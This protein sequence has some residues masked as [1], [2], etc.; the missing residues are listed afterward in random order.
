MPSLSNYL[1]VAAILFGIGMAG[2]IVNR[3]NIIVLLMSIELMLL[4]S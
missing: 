3:K 1:V 4:S 2:V